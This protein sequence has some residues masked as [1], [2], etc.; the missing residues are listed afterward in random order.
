ME[1]VMLIG[2][3]ASGKT[4]FYQQRFF[5][6]HV[7]ISLDL[8]GT[9][10]RESAVLDTCLRIQQRFVID[11]TNV[12][13]AERARYILPSRAAKFRVIGYFFKPDRK[14][15]FARNL[16]RTERERIPAA[17]FFGTLKRLEPPKR[18]EGFDHLY[19]VWI[20]RPGEFGIEAWDAPSRAMDI[21]HRLP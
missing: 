14:A 10:E 2:I 8:L 17:G 12:T 3:Q 7:R 20:L 9:R 6:T 11:N 18:S 1:A 16:S 19:R 15:A 4:T 13:A 21:A 5:A